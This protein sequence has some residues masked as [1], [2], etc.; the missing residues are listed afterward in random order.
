MYLCFIDS[1]FCV[2]FMKRRMS[3]GDLVEVN[4]G[5][6][7]LTEIRKRDGL[8]CMCN[9]DESTIRYLGIVMYLQLASIISSVK[10]HAASVFYPCRYGM[11]IEC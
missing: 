6:N 4:E 5:D 2:Y 8:F 9:Q 10:V 7:I 1:L 3:T 11:I